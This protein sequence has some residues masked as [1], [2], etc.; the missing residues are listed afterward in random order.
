MPNDRLLELQQRIERM[1]AAEPAQDPRET[2]AEIK[3]ILS[4]I[5]L[6]MAQIEAA[7]GNAAAAARQ[8]ANVASCLANGIKPD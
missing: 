1:P 2:M 6:E 7:L 4:L 5:V 8:A 3:T